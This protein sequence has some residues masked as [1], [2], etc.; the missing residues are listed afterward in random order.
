MSDREL[1]LSYGLQAV[2]AKGRVAV[3]AKL[4]AALAE[5]LSAMLILPSRW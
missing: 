5:Q 1:Y 4:R 3:P 2:D